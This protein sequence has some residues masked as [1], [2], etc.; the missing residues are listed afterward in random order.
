[1]LLHARPYAAHANPQVKTRVQDEYFA[2]KPAEVDKMLSRRDFWEYYLSRIQA[3]DMA[4]ETAVTQYHKDY[5]SKD[6]QFK[7]ETS[8]T[9]S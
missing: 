4:L 9:S 3:G 6:L 1:M 5:F 2:L 8:G 7:V